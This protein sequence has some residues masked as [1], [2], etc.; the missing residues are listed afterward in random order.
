MKPFL[1]LSIRH[2]DEAVTGEF[3]AIQRF[4]RLREGQLVHLRAEQ[5]PLPPL[6]P[7]DYSGIIIGGGQFNAS[8][9]VKTAEQLRVEDDLGRIL[10]L[11]LA[12]GLPL[13]GLCYGVGL[14][15]RHLGGVVD[16]TYS[17]TT[18]AV[19]ITLTPDGKN[20]PVFD[21]VPSTFMAFVGHKEACTQ[22]PDGAVQLASGTACPVQAFRVNE[23]VYAT[24]FHPEL[25]LDGLIHRMEV[26]RHSGYFPADEFDELVE[27]ARGA[28]VDGTPGIIL[29][30]FVERFAR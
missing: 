19:E 20:D 30:N 5:A 13:I 16:G 14:V 23:H 25:D 2:H 24:Q 17:E 12:E 21:G 3:D 7:D 27:V 15:T 1:H 10:D 28:G 6:N 18:S 8:D 9:E 26:Y 22:M 4:G 11:A 29:R